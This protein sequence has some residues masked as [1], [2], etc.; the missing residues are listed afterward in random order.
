MLFINRYLW[1]I[2]ATYIPVCIFYKFSK[3]PRHRPL[4]SSLIEEKGPFI[5]HNLYHGCWW[6]GDARSH[7]ISSREVDLVI[8]EYTGFSGRRAKRFSCYVP[9]MKLNIDIWCIS[10]W[11]VPSMNNQHLQMHSWEYKKKLL[12]SL[13][14]HKMGNVARQM[15]YENHLLGPLSLT[16]INFNPNMDKYLLTC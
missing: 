6:T 9:I 14:C 7:V 13:Q 16:Q 2:N 10:V 12:V 1:N 3:L 5:L 11:D 8:T 4:K 15:R